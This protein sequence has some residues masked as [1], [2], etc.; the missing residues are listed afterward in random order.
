MI[1]REDDNESRYRNGEKVEEE[2]A[3]IETIGVGST[4][5]VGRSSAR[6]LPTFSDSTI[7]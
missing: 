4:M 3:S 5:V 1:D 6:P 2:K 7:L